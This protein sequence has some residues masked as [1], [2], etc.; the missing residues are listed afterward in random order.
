MITKQLANDIN[1]YKFFACPYSTLQEFTVENEVPFT[2]H[3][4]IERELHVRCTDFSKI[5]KRFAF[6][7]DELDVP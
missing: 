4:E 2:S 1:N 3:P 5:L 7:T 6:I